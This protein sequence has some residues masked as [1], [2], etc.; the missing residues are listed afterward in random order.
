MGERINLKTLKRVEDRAFIDE[1][2]VA[3]EYLS[4]RDAKEF[5]KIV[6]GHFEY[7][8]PVKVGVHILETIGIVC[9]NERIMDKFASGGYILNL[10]F[11][12]KEYSS[13]VFDVL[14]KFARRDPNL[15]DADVASACRR[16]FK[17]DAERAL[18]VIAEVCVRVEQVEDPM[19]LFELLINE[20]ETFCDIENVNLYVILLAH[21]LSDCR[22]FKKLY[23][24]KSIRIITQI[25]KQIDHETLSLCYSGLGKLPSD[26]SLPVEMV[27]KHL[28]SSKTQKS[29]LDYLIMNPQCEA[30][31]A[32]VDLL[33]DLASQDVQKATYSLFQIA[34]TSDGA[35]IIMDN[36]QWMRLG[37]PTSEDTLRLMLVLFQHK[38]L[39]SVIADSKYFIKFLHSV[40]SETRDVH[41]I[42]CI[43][44]ML[45]RV[46]LDEEMIQVMSKSG[47]IR[48]YFEK[49]L[50]IGED[51][52]I[53]SAFLLC[54]TIAQICYT[55]ELASMCSI[56][57]D[58]AKEGGPLSNVAAQVAADLAGYDRCLDK[59]LD[60]RMDSFFKKKRHDD[61]LADSA[62]MFFEY[63][64]Q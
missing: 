20:A 57:A 33:L 41:V 46:E 40:V 25:M 7:E 19:P 1:L 63:A 53:H 45:R 12:Q 39:R 9:K 55:K 58:Y 56:L 24:S 59:L 60:K 61:K 50:Q 22:E 62:R 14:D 32:L 47:F 36:R 27:T 8:I 43:C 6:L 38:K 30:D 48:E 11:S 10:P 13:S 49:A 42:V 2:E 18:K 15:F 64:N 5:F 31:D 17:R 21:C 28:R 23:A 29:V 3:E 16:L 54:D 26:C 4:E 34:A 51:L 37:L 35:A 44:T 52:G